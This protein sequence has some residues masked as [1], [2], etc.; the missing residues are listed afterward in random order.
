MAERAEK[1]LLVEPDA[2]TLEAIVAALSR[3]FD[4]QITCVATADACLEVELV[5]PH[6][7]IITELRLE[8]EEEDG[9]ELIRQLTS[10]S[11]RPIIVLAD[12]PGLSDA[13]A[14]LRLGV[15][16]MFPKPC[17]MAQ[18]LDA[19]ELALRTHQVRR[20]QA[21]KYRRNRELLRRVIRER[22]DLNRRVELICR[23]LV[24]AHRRLV[25]RVLDSEGAGTVRDA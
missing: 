11:A 5:E 22:R 20:T 9:L 19:V 8:E 25:H 16:D 12:E 14:A 23:D 10:L 13:L 24:G 17:R 21:V 4:V 2:D 1:I 3:R 15:A 7:L 6:N 18:L